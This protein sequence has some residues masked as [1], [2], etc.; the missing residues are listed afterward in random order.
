M[1]Y[2]DERNVYTPTGITRTTF[3]EVSL[4]GYKVGKCKCGKRRVRREKFWGTV[5]P[6]NRNEDGTIKTREQ[7][8]AKV[9]AEHDTWMKE[10]IL[11][12]NCPNP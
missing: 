6:F 5:N 9:Q 11:C 4:R 1:N 8:A 2:T 3:A 12:D 10:P 7:V